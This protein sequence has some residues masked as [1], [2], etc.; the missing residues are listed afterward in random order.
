MKLV[1]INP[2]LKQYASVGLFNNNILEER[3]LEE[4]MSKGLIMGI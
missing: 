4:R 2:A 1:H 3:P